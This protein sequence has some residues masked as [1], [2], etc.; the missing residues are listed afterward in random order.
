MIAPVE[1]IIILYKKD[2][3]KNEKKE[4]DITKQEFMDWT[5][6]LWTF[7]GQSKKRAGGHPAPFP[8]ELPRRCIN[9]LVL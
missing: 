7:P 2:W 3:K 5:N 6:G 9:Y 4:S 8:V 1:L